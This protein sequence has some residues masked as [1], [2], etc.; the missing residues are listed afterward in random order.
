MHIENPEHTILMESIHGQ[1]N[2][3]R[4]WLKFMEKLKLYVVGKKCQLSIGV[5]I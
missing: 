1:E 4:G 2:K 3:S 5:F